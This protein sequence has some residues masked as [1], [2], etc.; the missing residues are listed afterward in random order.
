VGDQHELD[1]L[2]APRRVGGEP[3]D[4]SHP[5]SPVRRS[6]Y[7][8]IQGTHV[9]ILAT[10]AD[11]AAAATVWRGRL[12]GTIDDAWPLALTALAG[13]DTLP[14]R[15]PAFRDHA[16]AIAA[17]INADGAAHAYPDPPQTPLFHVHLPAARRAIERAGAAML[18]EHGVQVYGRVRSG[19]DPARCSFEISVGDNAMEFTPDE[20]V[21][22]DPRTPRP[23]RR[24]TDG[25]ARAG[26]VARPN[27]ATRF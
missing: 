20:V 4:S 23:G 11:T 24:L 21:R 14:P 2:S 9:A 26:A 27:P 5:A 16:I 7:K 8:S 10:D 18:A 1:L 17:A 13:L 15:M 6:L 3:V 12:G 25:P 19:P 22:T